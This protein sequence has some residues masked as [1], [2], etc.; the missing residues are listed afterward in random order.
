MSE[1]TPPATTA[2]VPGKPTITGSSASVTV[3]FG[4]TPPAAAPAVDFKTV[5]PADFAARPYM[6][7]VDSMDKLFKK[8][9]GAMTLIGKRPAGVPE[10]GAPKEK[11]DEFYKAIGR[12][13]APTEYEFEKVE[14]LDYSDEFTASVK[15]LMHSAGVPKDMAKNLQKGFDAIQLQVM[16]KG[17]EAEMAADK[18]FDTLIAPHMGTET[19]KALAR[20]QQLIKSVLPAEL[21]PHLDKLTPGQAALMAVVINKF[22]DKYVAPDK[23]NLG[24]GGGVQGGTAATLQTQARA[25]MAKPEYWRPDHPEN[26]TLQAQ[27]KAIYEKIGKMQKPS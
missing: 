24:E 12:P 27:V 14:G 22:A 8:L 7:D 1:T 13:E 20:S 23:L 16:K 26:Q 18:E 6:S 4:A 17:Q 10:A 2:A 3:P 11:W 25:L 21:A 15:G 19:D 9:D 5:V